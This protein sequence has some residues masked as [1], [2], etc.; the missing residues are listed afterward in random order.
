MQKECLFSVRGSDGLAFI[1]GGLKVD[2]TITGNVS[3]SLKS[4]TQITNDFTNAWTGLS[5]RFGR[6]FNN[7][8]GDTA[9][10]GYCDYITCGP[11][12]SDASGGGNN[13]I[14]INKTGEIQVIVKRADKNNANNPFS[15][16]DSGL[17]NQSFRKICMLNQDDG[18]TFNGNVGIGTTN[19]QSQL[20][21][22]GTGDVQLKIDADSDNVGEYDNPSILLTQ[23]G[24]AVQLKMGINGVA[25]QSITNSLANYSY[26]SSFAPSVSTNVGLQFAT[27]S[28]GNGEVRMTI[29]NVG[30]VGIGVTSPGAKLDVNGGNTG[31][32]VADLIVKNSA[33]MQ[34]WCKNRRY[35]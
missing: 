7:A 21:L 9:Q 4:I 35:N 15:D 6:N 29:D 23:D 20:H 11:T 17:N 32:D 19:P 34:W 27:Q 28:N 30:K 12:W 14:A 24:E 8:I 10:N 25:E 2:G 5:L 33:V 13:V 3:G 18:A 16:T 26:L 1:K 22:K 31:P